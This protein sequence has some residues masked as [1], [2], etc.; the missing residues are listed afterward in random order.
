MIVG[1]PGAGISTFFYLLLV[2]VMPV[3][4]L[5]RMAMGRP[6]PAGHWRRI[7]RQWAMALGIVG[8]LI[9]VGLLLSLL[10]DPTS[11]PA[12][13]PVGQGA[14]VTT[15]TQDLVTSVARLGV[16][17]ALLTLVLLL[18][19]IQV[20]AFVSGLRRRRQPEAGRPATPL[21]DA[22]RPAGDR[23]QGEPARIALGKTAVT[24]TSGRREAHPRR[25]SVAPRPAAPG[26]GGWKGP[27]T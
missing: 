13:G 9:G 11:V 23:P 10:I 26:S 14:P 3:H 16:L 6:L 27:K 15:G 8:V 20:L 7:A 17:V 1:L 21:M 22:S 19:V 5:W 25:G 18:S 4:A 24:S 2:A 12:A